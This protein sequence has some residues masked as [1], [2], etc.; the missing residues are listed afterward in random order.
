MLFLERQTALLLC[1]TSVISHYSLDEIRLS[2]WNCNF[3]WPV[4]PSLDIRRITLTREMS[5]RGISL[6]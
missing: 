1:V 5:T 4:A 3:Y 2:P 6:G